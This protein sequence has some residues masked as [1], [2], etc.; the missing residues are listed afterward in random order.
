M[1]ASDFFTKWNGKSIDF[2]GYYGY[3]CMDL[4]QQY[5]KDVV[6]APS[7]PAA[8]ARLVWESNLYPKDF[9]TK[10]VN[11]P[12]AIPQKGDVIIWS[13]A[14][15]GAGGHIAVCYSA[16]L[17]NFTS[18]DQNWNGSYCHFQPHNYNYVEG[19]LR[20]KINA[21]TPLTDGQKL[22]KVRDI[23][24]DPANPVNPTVIKVREAVS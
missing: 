13:N 10:I 6:G 7:V 9:Y 20:P 14:I 2:D 5:N 21:P 17:Y 4:Y 12:D 22:Q 16:D 8:Y 19:W 18:F 24:N 11:T 15:N 1:T 3:Q 23:V